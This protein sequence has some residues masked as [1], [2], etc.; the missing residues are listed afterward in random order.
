MNRVA[1]YFI[2]PLS[3]TKPVRW[4]GVGKTSR[5]KRIMRLDESTLSLIGRLMLAVLFLWAGFHKVFNPEGT[6]QYMA[7]YGLT[8]GTMLLYLAATVIEFA[9]GI[10]LAL[11]H[12]TR[13][14]VLL[15]VLFMVM[16]T[17]I[18]HIHLADPNQVIHFAKNLAIIGGLFY[19]G[20]YGPGARS[21]DVQEHVSRNSAVADSHFAAL[22]LTGRMLLGGLL[23]LSGVNQILDP[24]GVR[25]YMAALGL[26][27]GTEFYYAG[28]VL[29]EMGGALSLWLGWHARAGAAALILFLIAATAVFH[30]T[31][32]SF[33]LDATI[34]D[35]QFHVMKN[36]AIIGG[37]AYVAAY[38]AGP[39]SLDARRTIHR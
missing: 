38:G 19:I 21:M 6:Q 33:V 26:L 17:G 12:T 37:L 5:K 20:A 32:M 14:A 30:R 15:L 31:S 25:R 39:I 10:A 22:T 2:K 8:M 9:G 13:D 35:Q 27:S 16:V 11:G 18:F 34:Q 23:I 36:V 29:L 4:F 28:A 7:T 1:R 24:E 3:G